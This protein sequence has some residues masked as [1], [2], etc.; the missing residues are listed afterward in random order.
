[1]HPLGFQKGRSRSQ[2]IRQWYGRTHIFRL[3]RRPHALEICVA[4]NGHYVCAPLG[5]VRT[6]KY[7]QA[8]LP[9]EDLDT[10]ETSH[11]SCVE[12]MWGYW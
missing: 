8:I 3:W 4:L 1:M 7:L 9:Q 5:W 2:G 11:S 6:P 12:E 10:R